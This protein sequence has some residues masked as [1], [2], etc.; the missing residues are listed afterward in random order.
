MDIK[1]EIIHCIEIEDKKNPFTDETISDKLD[2]SREVITRVRKELKIPDSRDRRKNELIRVIN[3]LLEKN[4]HISDRALTKQL[5]DAQFIVGKYVVSKIR[6]ELQNKYPKMNENQNAFHH[7]IGEKGSLKNIIQQ[8]IA[9]VSY[10]PNGLHCCLMGGFG[11]GRSVLVY[12]MAEY[13]KILNQDKIVPVYEIDCID[14]LERPLILLENLFGKENTAGYIEQEELAFIY[15][16]NIEFFPPQ[17]LEVLYRYLDKRQFTRLNDNAT[18]RTSRAL[19]IS[20]IHMKATSTVSKEILRHFAMKIEMPKYINR[21][22]TERIEYIKQAFMSESQQMNLDITVRRNVLIS[23]ASTD[24]AENMRQLFAEVKTACAKAFV[25]SKVNEKKELII[26][27]RFLSDTFANLRTQHEKDVNT[28][29]RGDLVFIAKEEKIFSRTKL[30]DSWDNYSKLEKRFTELK[31]AG[32]PNEEVEKKLSEEIEL[33]LLQQIRDVQKNKL[34]REEI[35]IIAGEDILNL[36]QSIYERARLDLPFLNEA[37][38]FPLAVHLKMLKDRQATKQHLSSELKQIKDSCP[39]EFFVARN[40][41][42]NLSS[43][44]NIPHLNEEAG[45]LAIYFQKFQS[46]YNV[47]SKRIA[48]LVVSHGHVASAMAEAANVILGENHAYG[49][50]LEYEDTPKMMCDKVI[51]KV[52]QIDEG[53]GTIILADMGS[54]LQV[55]AKVEEALGIHVGVLGRADTLLVIECMRKTLWTQDS[56]EEILTSIDE[57]ETMNIYENQNSPKSKKPAILTCCITGEGAAIHLE[58]YIR[59]QFETVFKKLEWLHIGYIDE[60]GIQNKITAL[61]KEY[62]IVACVGTI[63][64]NVIDLPFFS[65]EEIHQREGL[66]KLKNL[67]ISNTNFY[68][69]L[70]DVLHEDCVYIEHNRVTKEEIL[71][72]IVTK[73]ANDGYVTES[74]LLSVYKRESYLPTYLKGNMAIPHGETQFVTKPVIHI[75]KLDKPIYWDGENKVDFIFTIAIDENHRTA[76][77]ELYQHIKEPEFMDILKTCK[78]EKEIFKKFFG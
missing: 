49:L 78:T 31:Q 34:S 37:I 39:K 46:N 75:T 8:A 60:Q 30:N 4:D 2:L 48:V 72:K 28:W 6:T 52:K 50:D 14:Y 44:V 69:P 74:F 59:H 20:S 5:N 68:N 67:V 26:E 71:D 63:N 62:E 11:S 57:K 1:K 76:F 7:I 36:S 32:L 10:P 16:K 21:T 17:G 29:I 12:A 35:S 40:I 43:K 66:E 77:E 54:L 55:R 3:D 41:L 53:K 38:V 13:A 61:S 51:S 24:Y 45:Y 70:E 15:V 73:L 65:A 56:L 9:A 22:L 33:S 18:I 42:D 64:P 58:N 19:I 27:S 47:D 25:E 23:L